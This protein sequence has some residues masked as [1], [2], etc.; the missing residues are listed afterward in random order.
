MAIIFK[1]WNKPVQKITAIPVENLEMIKN[2]LDESDILFFE[3]LYNMNWSK[4]FEN[5]KRDPEEWIEEGGW[6]MLKL[7]VITI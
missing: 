4:V 2:W 1:D 7:E 6:A 3:G 5:I